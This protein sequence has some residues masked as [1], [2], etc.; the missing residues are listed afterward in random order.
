MSRLL[1]RL[2]SASARRP[3]RV[4]SVWVLVVGV[5]AG[6]SFVAGGSL[7]DNY[8]L[9]GT[10]SQEATDLLKERF[11][12]LS[13]ADGR[14]VIHSD[15]GKVDQAKVQAA[16]ANMRKLPHV[17]EVDAVP[18]SADGRTTMLTVRYDVPVTELTPSTTLD[19]LKDASTDLKAA[20]YKVEFGGQVPE[21]VTA[22]GGVAESVGIVAA[23]V[24]LFLAF[25][26]IVAA[27]LPLA[28]ALAGL[29]AGVSGITILAAFTDVANTAPTLAVMVG[30]GVGIDY[31]LFILTRHREGLAQGLDV[32]ESV[33]RATATAGQS[34][35]FAGF[36]V[37]LALCGLVLSRIPVFITMGFATGLVVAATV[38]SAVTLLPAVLGLAGRRVL[39][40]RDRAPGAVIHA[41]SPRVR[42]WADNVARRP[43]AWLLTALILMLTLAA[44]AIGMRTWPSDASSEPTSNTVRRAYDLIDSAYG[45]GANAPLIIA[46]DLKKVSP[47]ALPSVGAKLAKTDGVAAVMPPQYAPDR[48]AAVIVVTPKFGPQDEKVTDLVNRIRADALPDGAEVTGYTAAYV[49]LSRVLGERLWPVIGVVVATSFVMLMIVFRSLLAPLKAAAMNLLSIGAAYGVLTAIFQWG[50]GAELLGLPHSVPVSSF[51]LLLMF[52]V[53]FGVSMDYEVFLLSRVRE[54]WLRTGDARGSVTT[55]LGATGRVISSA[56]LIMVAVFLGFALDPGLV[57]KQM[58]VGLAVAV[59]L[60]ATL[61]R[62]VLVPATMSLLGKAN[63]WLPGW[64][65]RML[66]KID[67]HGGD[68]THQSA[69]KQLTNA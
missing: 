4:I 50:W 49:D 14:V 38:A 46:A 12:A 37:L 8:R 67:M 27:G 28:V 6:I 23:L 17:S 11:P 55:G 20:G 41:D 62:L 3:W 26:S 68:P 35:I 48:S 56:A 43:W 58:G 39:R 69:D 10:G 53:L 16:G 19:H 60:D 29:G 36:T 13:G 21:N 57:I 63:W 32:P 47:D 64:L 54:E 2:G 66:P 33:G 18:P 44:P 7:H 22:P 59:A 31:A 52:A 25:G 45:P 9:K 5:V 15:A 34:V 42:K 40:K 24:I 51:I 61:V 65:D 1:Y 30:L